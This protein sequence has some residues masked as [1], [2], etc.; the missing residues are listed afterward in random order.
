MRLPAVAVAAAFACGIAVGLHPVVAKDISSKTLLI[1]F[2]VFA[3]MFL[4]V[5]IILVKQGRLYFASIASLLC[6]MMLGLAGICIADQPRPANHVTSMIEQG[7]LPLKT[8]LRWHGYL[9][10]EPTRLPW[11]HGYEIEISGVEF[12][13]ALRPALGG[14]RLSF[15]TPAE[16]VRP[17]DIHA[18]DAVAVLTE[19]KQPQM[20]K[21]EGAF[22]RRALPGATKY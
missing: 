1:S 15:T 8:P 17:P 5:G 22:D 11:G 14:L 3:V 6:W 21:D 10:D 12:E 19:A 13:E 9:R 2:L 16:E 4:L 20:F 7:R 18:G